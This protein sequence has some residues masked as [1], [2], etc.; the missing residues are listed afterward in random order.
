MLE[1]RA[2]SQ[3]CLTCGHIREFA[4]MQ[5]YETNLLDI[6]FLADSRCSSVLPILALGSISGRF[7]FA[8]RGMPWV[9]LL[10]FGQSK[11]CEWVH[12]GEPGVER[13]FK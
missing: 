2:A 8:T 10:R 4:F 3:G 12:T 11:G 9:F 13:P 6:N 7:V 5:Q 1:C